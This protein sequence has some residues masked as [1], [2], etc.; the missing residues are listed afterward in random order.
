M[1]LSVQQQETLQYITT[2]LTGSQP[3]LLQGS[4]GTGKTTL[5]KSISDYYNSQQNTVICAI[6]PTHK[7]KKVI[8]HVLNQ[9]A[10]L[11]ISA[12][13]VASA[14][15]KIKE[16][17]YVGTKNYSAGN[18]KKL[19]AYSLFII[20]EVS[21]IHDDDLRVIMDF[22]KRFNK[23]LLI[24]GD[25]NQ[26][27]C[28][29]AK[30]VL[31]EDGFLRRADSFVFNDPGVLKVKLTQIMRQSAD[32]PIIQL[33]TKI[34]DNL[35]D[36]LTLTQLMG[37]DGTS[38]SIV[39]DYN[40][41]HELF[42]QHF[43][44]NAPNSARIIAYTNSS[45]K[46]HNMEIRAAMRYDDELVVGELLTGYTNIGW[47]ELIVENGE[48]Y[49]VSGIKH[50]TTHTIEKYR[51]LSGKLVD[52]YI[53]QISVNALHV[54]HTIVPRLF[55]I[56][57]N[58]PSNTPFIE[59][60]IALAENINRR[61]STKLD[62]QNYVQMKEQ[63]IFMEDIYKYDGKIYTEH[64]FKESH[65]LLFMRV[66]ELVCQ[67]LATG[68]YEYIDSAASKKI[69]TAYKNI[70]VDRLRDRAKPVSDSE[71]L[72][73]KYKVI[74]KDMYY[75]YAITAHKSQGSTY[76]T[77]IVDN[78]DL[79]KITNKW[80][81]R[82]GKMESRIKEKNQLRYVAFTRAKTNLFI[83]QPLVSI[84]ERDYAEYENTEYKA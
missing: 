78:M 74:E 73:D 51:G 44:P 80:N 32:S 60:L 24:I 21:M 68:E 6:A 84:G 31:C 54:T 56:H 13:T 39:I 70:I 53:P 75:G 47:P 11:P 19:S 69:N 46:T 40:S 14:L 63:V 59:N 67:N 22:A 64:S 62:Y 9:N 72:A 34:R 65:P 29:N 43:D 33:A 17:S 3:V 2:H 48:D 10:I 36:D 83:I 50:V 20:D 15:G 61:D 18:S 76:A 58:H 35:M 57:V 1:Q 55:F 66:G 30:L 49:I 8:K 79:E 71:M 28:P 82:Y 4:A 5:T 37:T 41:A 42:V 52:M 16:H 7:A 27:P 25:D 45:V 23:K 81:Y 38:S 77:A 26:I 12:L